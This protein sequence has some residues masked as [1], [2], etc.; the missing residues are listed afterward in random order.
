MVDDDGVPS[1][2]FIGCKN[3][4]PIRINIFDVVQVE[5]CAKDEKLKAKIVAAN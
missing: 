2:Q 3:S 5:V 1:I 4:S